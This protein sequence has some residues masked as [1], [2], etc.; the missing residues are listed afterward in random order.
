[1]GTLEFRLRA[2]YF[3][4]VGKVGKTPPGAAHGHLQCPIPPPPDPPFIYG[5]DTKEHNYI[6]PAREKDRTPFCCAARCR[7]MVLE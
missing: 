1:M 4:H 6:H 7:S 5:G 2:T 3:A